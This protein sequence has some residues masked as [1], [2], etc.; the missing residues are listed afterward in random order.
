MILSKQE[1][2]VVILLS[3]RDCV[4]LNEE[5]TSHTATGIQEEPLLHPQNV[6]WMLVHHKHS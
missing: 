4:N 2:L 5:P 3:M 6:Q 1:Y